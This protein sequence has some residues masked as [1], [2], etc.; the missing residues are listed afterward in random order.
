MEELVAKAKLGDTKAFDELISLFEKDLQKI[1]TSR[2]A[3]KDYVNDIIQNTLIKA[4]LNLDKLND[5]TKFKSWLFTILNHECINMNKKIL[6]YKEVYLND[7]EDDLVDFTTP[8]PDSII[9]FEQM[10]SK[11]SEDE[12]K[13]IRM[14]FEENYSNLEISEELG[15]P[16]NTVKSKINRALK[17]ISLL[18]FILVILSGLTV[19][20]TFV[21]KQIKAHFTTS[22][23]AIDSAVENDYV[24][25]FDEDFVYSNGI[26]IKVDAMVLDDKNMNI[27]F[28]YDVLDKEKYGEIKGI[29]I[30]NY[31][32]KFE[33]NILT[34]S[35]NEKNDTI[36]I[37][38]QYHEKSEKVDNYFR[39]SY[40][41]STINSLSEINKI[42]L[43]IT[44]IHVKLENEKYIIING[45]WNL[46][47]NIE[48]KLNE[49]FQDSYLLQNNKY[50]K[51]YNVILQDT[52]IK[53]QLNFNTK[54]AFDNISRCTL[55]NKNNKFNFIDYYYFQNKNFLTI[56]FDLG[57]YTEN[58]NNLTLEIPIENN[59]KIILKFR[60]DL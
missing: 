52:S 24:Q 59:E 21:I 27:S 2:L 31:V 48:E 26:G 18:V 3:N 39:N 17:K 40:L 56:S 23:N 47:Y 13:I 8:S 42:F 49:R 45:N 22:L 12:K 53:F 7:Y 35:K 5:N 28:V 57:K 33:D 55:Y 15:I 16:Y 4:F 54:L 60:R 36:E 41:F 14:K 43:E 6:Q 37:Y 9:N 10:I 34:D 20:A 46:E 1:A 38:K 58:I 29:S 19:L 50:V 44:C 25:T 51:H 11:L 32:I 30:K